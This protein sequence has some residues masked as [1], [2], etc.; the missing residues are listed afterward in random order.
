MDA[1]LEIRSLI[2]EY[3]NYMILFMD[4]NSAKTVGKI[5]LSIIDDEKGCMLYS[6]QSEDIRINYMFNA[7]DEIQSACFVSNDDLK[8]Y[9][10][11]FQSNMM[12]SPQTRAYDKTLIAIEILRSAN[13]KLNEL[14]EP[15]TK[16]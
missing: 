10:Y 15:K 4:G 14:L 5:K 8:N 1:N 16:A 9:W 6:Y 3:K 2:E 13:Q 11:H 7:F 12:V